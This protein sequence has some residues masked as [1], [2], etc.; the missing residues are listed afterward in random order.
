[1]TTE[2]SQHGSLPL[3]DSWLAQLT[4]TERNLLRAHAND[5]DLPSD[6]VDLI[7]TGP[8]SPMQVNDR[9]T[10]SETIGMPPQI[11]TALG[12]MSEPET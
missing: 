11:A 8:L 2:T 3:L 7:N 4:A 6:V 10:H 1:M 5:T 12:S 9:P